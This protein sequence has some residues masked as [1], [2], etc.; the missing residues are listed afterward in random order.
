MEDFGRSRGNTSVKW[1]YGSQ[2]IRD[3]SDLA[4]ELSDT[5]KTAIVPVQHLRFQSCGALSQEDLRAVTEKDSV[6]DIIVD[7]G[8]SAR[9]LLLRV[10]LYELKS[11]KVVK[12]LTLGHQEGELQRWIQ[13]LNEGHVL[14]NAKKPV[15]SMTFEELVFLRDAVRTLIFSI[16][17]ENPDVRQGVSIKDDRFKDIFKEVLDGMGED[18]VYRFKSF[19]LNK[20]AS[21]RDEDGYK[22]DVLYQKKSLIYSIAISP[23]F[24]CSEKKKSIILVEKLFDGISRNLL[25][26]SD[27]TRRKCLEIFK[28]SSFGIPHYYFR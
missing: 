17:F 10:D 25:G 22:G 28:R 11:P 2:I 27:Q 12:L 1:H 7:F 24:S 20:L 9:R 18:F 19:V 15:D 4:R 5:N 3:E 26:I 6:H 21:Y 23:S 8:E 13:A 14:L 16:D